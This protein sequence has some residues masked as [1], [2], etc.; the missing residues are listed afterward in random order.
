MRRDEGQPNSCRFDTNPPSAAGP[1]SLPPSSILHPP[2]LPSEGS[3][4]SPQ[5]PSPSVLCIFLLTRSTPAKQGAAR[6]FFYTEAQTRCSL[7]HPLPLFF[8]PLRLRQNQEVAGPASLWS[9]PSPS[10]LVSDVISE[11]RRSGL[12]EAECREPKAQQF[13]PVTSVRLQ[14]IN[15]ACSHTSV[16][17]G[18]RPLS[19]TEAKSFRP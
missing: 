5:L 11:R 18:F 9:L 15:P 16:Y 8:I 10:L 6:S 13:H 12:T 2:S 1:P 4:L 17:F 19:T 3:L 7:P 14:D